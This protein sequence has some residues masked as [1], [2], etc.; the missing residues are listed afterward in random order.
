[1]TKR[2]AAAASE[3]VKEFPVYAVDEID[4]AKFSV[5][6]RGD[7]KNGKPFFTT[8]YDGQKL[9]LNLTPKKKWLHLPYAIESSNYVAKEEG[10]K[11]ETLR[12]QVVLDDDA[13]NV[14][15]QIGQVAKEQVM[16]DMPD[17]KWF[18]AVKFTDQGNLFTGKLVLKASDEKDLTLCTV[19]PFKQELV[20]ATGREV[21]GPLLEAN[22]GLA[23]SKVKVSVSLHAVWFMKWSEMKDWVPGSK[24]GLN[25]GL[26][27][28][29]T[30]LVADVPEQTKYVHQDVFADVVFDD[31][32]EEE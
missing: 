15:V 17:V 3:V 12:I 25:A 14:L 11:T 32:E 16:K 19:R 8:S 9:S 27:W 30:N 26:T 21:L 6:Q 18:D 5:K 31:E 4:V 7:Q 13:T 24:D 23:K 1:M 10:G 28:R 2:S 22:R 20:K 29:I